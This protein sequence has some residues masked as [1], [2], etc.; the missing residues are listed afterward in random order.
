M[1]GQ[2][3]AGKGWSRKLRTAAGP[4]GGFPADPAQVAQGLLH[5]AAAEEG[6]PRLIPVSDA[7]AVGGLAG[8]A[9]G[10]HVGELIQPGFREQAIEGLLDVGGGVLVGPVHDQRLPAESGLGALSHPTS[11]D[12]AL[13]VV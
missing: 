7:G 12:A 10:G 5:A 13:P 3:Y 9:A 2:V 1:P 11:E 8:D 6:E 4:G